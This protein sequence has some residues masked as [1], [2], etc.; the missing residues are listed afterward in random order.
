MPARPPLLNEDI[1]PILR[2]GQSEA[3]VD[4]YARYRADFFHWAGR[5]FNANRQDFE[6]AWQESVTAFYT[7]VMAGK[8]VALRYDIRVWLFAV[9][10]KNLL[11]NNRKLKRYLWKDTIDEALLREAS[12]GDYQ[13][14]QIQEEK[15]ERLRSAMKTMSNQCREMLVQRYF[16][17][18][19]IAEIQQ[20]WDLS[21]INTASA[22]LSRC[23]KR[24][25]G[26]IKS[27]RTAEV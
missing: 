26:L 23:L 3:M 24:L 27:A 21:N 8:L 9:G 25:K 11:K 15:K 6:D 14:N 1:I 12:W 22:T 7:Q 18:K 5:R 19:S 2:S 13:E 10:Y 4:I 16:L 20:D 17:E